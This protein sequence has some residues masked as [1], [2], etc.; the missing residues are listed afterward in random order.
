MAKIKLGPIAAGL[1]YYGMLPDGQHYPLGAIDLIS[2]AS[3]S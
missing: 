2:I 3:S 1:E